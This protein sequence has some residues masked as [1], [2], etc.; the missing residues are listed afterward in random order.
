VLLKTHIQ[1]QTEQLISMQET[2]DNSNT[3]HDEKD[4]K[5][6]TLQQQLD[7]LTQSNADMSNNSQAI[8]E[9]MVELRNALDDRNKRIS[10]LELNLCEVAEEREL[11]K[12]EMASQAQELLN[13]VKD[14]RAQLEEVR[15]FVV[16]YLFN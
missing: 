16:V 6:A 12:N 1:K 4:N 14:L 2:L 13:Q 3:M 15:L 5:I 9:Q 8:A 11:L 7:T 10:F